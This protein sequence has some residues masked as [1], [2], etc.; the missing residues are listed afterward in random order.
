MSH[1]NTEDSIDTNINKINNELI[2]QKYELIILIIIES[3][4]LYNLLH[5]ELLNFVLNYLKLNQYANGLIITNTCIEQIS[6]T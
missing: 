4:L 3:I 6:R 2:I 5:I 1:A